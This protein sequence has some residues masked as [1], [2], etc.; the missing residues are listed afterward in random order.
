MHKQRPIK[1][2]DASQFQQLAKTISRLER[3]ADPVAV[4]L[5]LHFAGVH[6]LDLDGCAAARQ[7]ASQS[8]R[9]QGA[10]INC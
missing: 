9:D 3:R 6:T 10:D 8:S 7:Q 1:S 2:A 4:Q 5:T